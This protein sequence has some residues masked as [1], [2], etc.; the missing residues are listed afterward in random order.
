MSLTARRAPQRSRKCLAACLVAAA[1]VEGCGTQSAQQALDRQFQEHPEFKKLTLAKFSGH[2]TVDGQSPSQDNQLFV[3]L[4]DPAHLEEA[5]HGK[6]PKLFASCDAEGKFSFSTYIAGDG[7]VAGK[8]V[9]TFVE[10]R[11]PVKSVRPA[12]S[13][14]IFVPP[15]EL[16]N[17]YNDPNAN[18][19][20]D[21][22][23][24]DLQP[25]G[26]NDYEFDLA[27]AGRDPVV[28]PG[29]GAWTTIVLH[30]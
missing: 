30:R 3:I 7:V 2:V 6:T 22:F 24:L 19:K 26:K 12:M 15:D 23:N 10:L 21:R 18:A 9:V 25:P 4:N 8:Y 5:A 14:L 29:P 1:F 27:V 16:K 20:E 28:T 11:R 13:Q 17:L